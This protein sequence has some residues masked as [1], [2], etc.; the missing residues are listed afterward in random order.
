M[1]KMILTIK[2]KCLRNRISVLADRLEWVKSNGK[3]M[4]FNG[5]II[6]CNSP[7]VTAEFNLTDEEEATL[8]NFISNTY[9]KS[10]AALTILYH[11]NNVDCVIS[12]YYLGICNGRY[13]ASQEE[14]DEDIAGCRMVMETIDDMISKLESI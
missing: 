2:L 5:Y 10:D 6:G 4:S 13:Q 3:P 9:T 12:E 11:I 7:R 8:L 1:N 14:L